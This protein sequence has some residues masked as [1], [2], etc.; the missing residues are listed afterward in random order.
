MRIEALK[1]P[2]VQCYEV[3]WIPFFGRHCV[4]K[5][6]HVFTWKQLLVF[7]FAPWCKLQMHWNCIDGCGVLRNSFLATKLTVLVLRKNQF[8]I[9]LN[10][11]KVQSKH[12][13]LKI[14][15]IPLAVH[16]YVTLMVL[17]TCKTK[18]YSLG[19]ICCVYQFWISQWLIKV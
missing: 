19:N 7:Q 3:K 8:P 4:S 10:H 16:F 18:N 15:C 5:N 2:S 11:N 14:H 17:H 12:L 13:T 6:R 9:S 1:I